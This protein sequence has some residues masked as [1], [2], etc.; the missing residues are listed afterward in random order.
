VG[1]ELTVRILVAQNGAGGPIGALEAPLREAGRQLEVWHAPAGRP[2]PDVRG[3]RGLVVLGGVA[4][5]DEDG[6]LPWI[7]EERRLLAAALEHDVPVLGLCLGAQLL[8]QASGGEAPHLGRLDLGWREIELTGEA[9]L[10]P[11]VSVLPARFTG[12]Q[13]HRYGL[14]P[15]AEAT[16]L[17][18]GLL[19]PQAFRVGARA[20][21]LQFHL[22]VDERIVSRW[23]DLAPHEVDA[24]GE[25]VAEL[26]RATAAEAPGSVE[27]A[28]AVAGRLA[29]L[30][31]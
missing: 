9:P 27:R 12:F 10:D 2:A 7:A 11:L 5:P 23:F 6:R 22:E 19:G 1:D 25:Q 14:R 30:T 3:Y 4:N 26:R 24:A 8:A 21:G 13:W 17:A 29:L 15:P 20:W 28:R 18:T 16:V 31:A